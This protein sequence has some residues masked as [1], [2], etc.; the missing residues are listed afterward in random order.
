MPNTTIL[1][2][3]GRRNRCVLT[4]KRGI[5]TVKW[6]ILTVNRGFLTVKEVFGL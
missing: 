3:P 4:A 5:F 1:S 6:A 2:P